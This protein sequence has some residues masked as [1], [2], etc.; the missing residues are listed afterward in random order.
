MTVAKDLGAARAASVAARPQL[1]DS[2]VTYLTL[3]RNSPL[4]HKIFFA[5]TLLQCLCIIIERI[6]LFVKTLEH[7][8]GV[9]LNDGVVRTAIYFLVIIVMSSMF[10][11]YFA[12]H[13][14]LQTNKYEMTAFFVSSLL[15]IARLAFEFTNDR[16]D[17]QT[18]E[19]GAP[20]SEEFTVCAVF[21]S[22]ALFF[23]VA[24][25]AFTT[26]MYKD[27]EWKRYKAIGAEVNTRRMYNLYEMFSAVRKLDLQ[28]SLITLVTGI[29]FFTLS[30]AG[31]KASYALI[32]NLLLFVVELLWE[33]LGDW[34][35][36]GENACCLVGFWSLS[37][38]LP[39]FI[40]GICVDVVMS[41][42]Q[43]VPSLLDLAYGKSVEFT[44]A[45]MAV[46]A[47][48]NRIATVV[49]SVILYAN[50]GPNYVGLRRIIMSDRKGKFNR[51]RQ[52]GP[53]G[54]N[55][56][57]SA[58]NVLALVDLKKPSSAQPVVNPVSAASTAAS[59]NGSAEESEY[60]PGRGAAGGAMQGIVVEDWSRTTLTVEPAGVA[61]I[62]AVDVS[63]PGRPIAGNPF[64]SN[65]AADGPVPNAGYG[66]AASLRGQRVEQQLQGRNR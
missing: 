65:A 50:F 7:A 8:G 5:L 13:S 45:T 17:D 10:V 66:I 30:P 58:S 62:A 31:D 11:G 27:L 64:A 43:G 12:I 35:V 61:S 14:V 20:G 3:M 42:D 36:K 19:C 44:I 48:L 25:M 56:S 16:E 18:D 21:F 54:N 40:I 51:S 24:A 34:G 39:T 38:L 49:C 33:R 22:L 23:V 55:A 9:D 1:D 2:N 46:A 59:I 29:V 53:G 28:F 6:W 47:I 37:V 57:K 4:R 26:S 32:T 52:R 15:L 60:D 63:G 41:G